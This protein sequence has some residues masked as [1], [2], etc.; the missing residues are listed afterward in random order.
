MHWVGGA[1]GGGAGGRGGDGRGE[2]GWGGGGDGELNKG[3]VHE[4]RLG[5]AGAPV[6]LNVKV[7]PGGGEWRANVAMPETTPSRE[8]WCEDRTSTSRSK[9]SAI[10]KPSSH[11]PMRTAASKFVSVPS[12]ET[13]S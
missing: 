11:S 9:C 2:G 12:S 13:M 3:S 7:L 4:M 5:W 6:A 10:I 8:A 1:D